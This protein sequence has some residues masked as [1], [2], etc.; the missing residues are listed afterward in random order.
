MGGRR[1]VQAHSVGMVNN[2]T[3]SGALFLDPSPNGEVAP[4]PSAPL[5]HIPSMPHDFVAPE[6]DEHLV[7][8]ATKGVDTLS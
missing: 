5:P 1:Q 4:P 3:G 8:D 6:F 7:P 2:T